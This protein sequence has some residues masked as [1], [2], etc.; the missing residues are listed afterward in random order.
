ML[1]ALFE[2]MRTGNLGSRHFA[3]QHA[4]WLRWCFVCLLAMGGFW[5]DVAFAAAAIPMCSAFGECIEAPPPEAPPTGGE[6]RAKR[7]GLFEHQ[8]S[9]ERGHERDGNPSPI[10]P[11]PLE[12]LTL[13]VVEIQLPGAP[14]SGC[15]SSCPAE[16]M[17]RPGFSCE[18]FR[19]PCSAV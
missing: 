6:L 5:P 18:I 14:S 12:P 2:S 15:R 17:Q 9:C 10:I 7:R 8:A 4:I 11:D 13:R 16:G 3:R 19:P 1:G